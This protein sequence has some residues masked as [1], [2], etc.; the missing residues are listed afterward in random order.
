[1]NFLAHF[2]LSGSS[3]SLLIGNY[4]GDFV[5]GKQYL[6]YEPPIA[7]GILL[8][9]EIDSFTDGH[10]VVH[11]SKTRLV[12]KYGHYSGVIVDMFYDHMLAVNWEKYS[13]VSLPRFADFSYKVLHRG[14]TLL[15]DKALRALQ[16]MSKHNWLVHYAELD[17]IANA[18]QGMARRTKFESKMEQSV[19]ELKKHY[20][21]FEKEFNTYFPL[22][23]EHAR[24][25]KKNGAGGRAS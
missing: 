5:K 13:S 17:G 18:L 12:P 19:E 25:F 14:V 4:L 20:D 23:I 1:M 10:A 2:Y 8:H 15:P 6:N 22:L 24:A 3:P 11:Q 7:K 16:H 9:R 21:M